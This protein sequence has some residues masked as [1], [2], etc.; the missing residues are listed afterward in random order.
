M[1]LINND[2]SVD[3]SNNYYECNNCSW[4]GSQTQKLSI[5]E[6]EDFNKIVCPDCHHTRFTEITNSVNER[7]QDLMG[8]SQL[9]VDT[10]LK[11][12]EYDEDQ[13][14]NTIVKEYIML[15]EDYHNFLE[16]IIIS[17]IKNH[18][19]INDYIADVFEV[20][21]SEVIETNKT[22]KIHELL[23]LLTFSIPKASEFYLLKRYKLLILKK[24]ELNREINKN[25]QELVDIEKRLTIFNN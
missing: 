16:S 7:L 9:M 5:R 24:R 21:K 12:M 17:R 8:D 18:E 13:D 22:Y 14:F 2:M 15:Q 3:Y 1:R 23:L 11:N 4:E 25:N 20:P 10:I 6:N 19:D